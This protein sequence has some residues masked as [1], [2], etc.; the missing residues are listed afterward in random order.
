MIAAHDGG[1]STTTCDKPPL[2]P[3]DIPTSVVQR[4]ELQVEFLGTTTSAL[5]DSGASI[6]AIS[7]KFFSTL[8]NQ[9]PAPKKLSTLPVTGVTISTAIQGRSKKITRQAYIPLTVFGND[10]PG[11]FLVI[12]HL[13]TDM[14]LGD[15]WLTR[16]G[17]ILNYVTHQVEFPRWNLLS[18]FRSRTGMGSPSGSTTK[19]S[20]NE[21][22]ERLMPNAIEHCIADISFV[23]QFS[24]SQLL[25]PISLNCLDYTRSADPN[26]PTQTWS[27]SIVDSPDLRE[28][29]RA[30]LIALLSDHRDIFNDRPGLN[31][32]YSCRFEVSEDVPFKV[33]PYPIPFSRRPAVEN[34]LQ[35][36]LQWGVVERCSS[37]YCNPI[38]CVSKADGSVRLCLDARRINRL[39]LPMRDSSPPLDELLARFG[40]KKFFSSL[41]FSAGYWQ[42]PLH[43][44]VR[45]FTA[46]VFEGRTY[47]FCVVPFGLNISNTAF[48]QALEAVLKI[49]IPGAE[50]NIS[51]LHVYVDDVLISSTSFDEHLERLATLFKKISL[52]GMTLKLSKCEFLRQK[53]KFLGQII[54]P[55]GMSMDPSKLQ[56]IREFP[57]PRNKKELQ[58][59][60]GFCNFY[61]KFSCH[62]ASNISPLIELIKKDCPWRFGYEELKLFHAVRDSFTERYLSHPHFDQCFY[63]QTDASKVGLGAELFQIST[64]GERRTISFASRTLNTAERNYSITELELLSIVFA[65]EKFRVFIL[66]YPVIVLTDHQA[67]TFL[68]QCRLRN[69]RLTRWTLHLQEFNLQVKHIPGSGNVID[70]LSRNPAGREEAEKVMPRFPC[71]L[72][73]T[74]KKVQAEFQRQTSSFKSICASQREDSTLNKIVQLLTGPHTHHTPYLEHY[75][76]FEGVLFYRRHQTTD[77][78]LVCIPNSRIDELITQVHYHFGHVGSK[79]CILAIRDFCI[80]KCF[81][82]RIRK[83][84]QSCEICQKAKVSTV[85]IEGEMVSVLADV[86]LGRVLVDLYGPLPPGWNQT[87]FIFVVLDN[88][89]RFVRLYP[90]KKATAVAVTNRMID[91]YISTYGNP[92]CIVSDHG[93]QFQSKVWQ[94]RLLAIGVPPTMT[95]VYHPQSNPAERVMR[96]L[97]RMFRTYCHDN[98]TEW[99]RSVPYI[100][101]VLNNTVHEST[102]HTPQELFLSVERYNPF[103]HVVNFPIRFP[104]AQRTKLT[105]A[106]EIQ[107]TQAE[108]RKRRHD[109]QGKPTI[110]T[111]GS[112]VLV[113]THRISSA[114][115]K[116]IKK[117]F[118]LYDGPYVIV[119]RSNDNAYTVADP[120]TNKIQGTYNVIHLRPFHEPNRTP[121]PLT[122]V[123]PVVH[124]P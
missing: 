113:R 30:K 42:V 77:Q 93:A 122:E 8:R 38:V 87:R 28:E 12:P 3:T 47:Q 78:W 46:F 21:K 51:D 101:W 97:G 67:L 80:F 82:S 68:F 44:S 89:S 90:I 39:I 110:F 75:S 45:K 64:D 116:C 43:P 83:V 123:I 114:A 65:C 70:A 36:M 41:D 35:R 50:D 120:Q 55:F 106:R 98:H 112:T 10:A 96:E 20:V 63:L 29:D 94:R 27:E 7:E 19:I 102:G 57:Q 79:K 61:R 103:S 111:V 40:G 66:G 108:R 49:K 26:H 22:L 124:S 119:K 23:R 91:H 59:F 105:M 92:Q 100:E 117:F 107:F 48:G 73:I 95:S 104:Q 72:T 18:P 9:V 2:T 17:V 56:A 81:Q 76:V 115:D 6:C 69:A 14:I 60:I 84:V 71:V 33:K 74:S 25:S 11:I 4:P 53:I 54:T 34:E 16:Y 31:G 99:P 118:L 1:Q 5:L 24:T 62:H 32:L 15:D 88:F 109:K 52:S 37:P 121:L 58:S 85:R 86:P 13:A